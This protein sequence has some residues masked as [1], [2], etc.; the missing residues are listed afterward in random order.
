[1]A[2][3]E[4]KP[5]QPIGCHLTSAEEKA[6]SRSKRLR[7]VALMKCRDHLN[8]LTKR[9]EFSK[10]IMSISRGTYECSYMEREMH[11]EYCRIQSLN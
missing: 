10:F 2:S 3:L 7:P 1:M 9:K 5:G 8:L 4:A 11:D 6:D